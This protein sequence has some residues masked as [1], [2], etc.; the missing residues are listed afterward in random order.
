MLALERERNALASQ[1][2]AYARLDLVHEQKME[3]VHAKHA[4]ALKAHEEKMEVAHVKHAQ[5]LKD[6]SVSKGG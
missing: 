3:A 6:A 4:Q 2:E 5:A 1:L